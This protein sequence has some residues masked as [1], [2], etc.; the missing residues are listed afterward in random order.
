MT[1]GPATPAP[2][3]MP[4]ATPGIAKTD[5]RLPALRLSL[6]DQADPIRVGQEVTYTLQVINQGTAPANA[7]T[8]KLD[9]PPELQYVSSDGSTV[10][11]ADGQVVA[12][13]NVDS[14]PAGQ[15]VTWTIKARANTAADVRTKAALNCEYLKTPVIADEPTRLVP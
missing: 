4:L 6:V 5:P 3:A 7:L 11:K 9:L 10:A 8:L 2:M 1:T 12:F 13:G 14:L 15:T